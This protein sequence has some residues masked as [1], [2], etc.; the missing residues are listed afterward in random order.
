MITA[1]HERR[2][3]LLIGLAAT[4]IALVAAAYHPGAPLAGVLVVWFLMLGA[5]GPFPLLL[6]FLVVLMLRPGDLVP[7]LAPW[8]L[9]KWA[10]LGTL[11]ITAGGKLIRGDFTW[12][13]APQNG[14][15]A[16]LTLALVASIVTGTDPPLGWA[17]FQEVF[18]KVLIVY[19]LI[20]NLADT[21]RRA[22]AVQLVVAVCTSILGA[23]ALVLK[24]TGGAT[25]EGS[26]AAFVGLLGDP[27]DLSLTLLMG[28]PFLIAAT[29]RMRGWAR[30]VF[31]LLAALTL[32]GMLASQSRGGLLALGGALYLLLRDRVRSRWLAV[33]AA[34]A[35]LAAVL[36]ASGIGQRRTVTGGGIDESAQ[37]RLDAWKAGLK[38]FRARPLTGVGY[39]TFEWRYPQYAVNPVEWGPKAAHN[40]W[41]KAIAETGL[42]GFVPFCWLLWVT[43]R[44]AWWLRTAHG[45]PGLAEVHRQT[46]FATFA[47]VL[48]AAFFLSQTWNWFLYILIAMVAATASATVRTESR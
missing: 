4:G 23:Y 28:A 13:R 35:V 7:E 21:P 25:I 6:L 44:M 48:V 31:A 45:P 16:W 41:I 26:R 39:E 12:R 33:G 27:N 11:A 2:R 22:L 32:G 3:D 36:L 14:L 5:L 15:L 18:S 17:R 37:G 34:A 24:A 30:A 46:L 29:A 19:V 43:G 9:G 40:S 42:F 1:A 8:Q 47:G 20:L 38:M 10:A